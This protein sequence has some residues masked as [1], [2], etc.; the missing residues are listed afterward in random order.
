[1][2]ILIVFSRLGLDP[3]F[4]LYMWKGKQGHLT[5]TDADF[6]DVIHTDGGIY[7]FPVSLGHADFFPNGGFPI[8]PGCR[9]NQLLK[10]NLINRIC[11]YSITLINLED[12]VCLFIR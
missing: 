7:G 11:K 10:Y 3:A 12:Y 5:S 4:P 2:S 6:V 1:M 9:L 8:Q